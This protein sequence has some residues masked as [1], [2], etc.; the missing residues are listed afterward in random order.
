VWG[1]GGGGGKV[2]EIKLLVDHPPP[3]RHSHASRN[4]QKKLQNLF[5]NTLQIWKMYQ[6]YWESQKENLKD[7]KAAQIRYQNLSISTIDC[8]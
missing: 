5:I 8:L 2:L 6:R 1:G 3:H 7:V 4:H